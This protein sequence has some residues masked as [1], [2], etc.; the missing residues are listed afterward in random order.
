MKLA[1]IG[2]GI[3]GLVVAYLLRKRFE[4]TVY[5]ANDYVGGHTNT[6]R[7]NRPHGDYDIDTGFIVY[8]SRTYPNFIQLLTQLDVGWQETNMGFGVRDDKI[9]FEYSSESLLKFFAQKKN[10]FRTNIYQLIWDILR[11]N[12]QAADFLQKNCESVTLFDYLIKENY[13]RVFIDHFIVPMGAA[14]WSSN[15][16]QIRNF[17]AH[18]FIRFFQNHG[19]LNVTNRVVWRVINEGSV[20]YVNK[21]VSHIRGLIRLNT[22]VN[23]IIRRGDAVQV[24]SRDGVATYDHVVVATHSDQALRLLKDSSEEEQQILGAIPYQ[25]KYCHPPYRRI[26]VTQKKTSLE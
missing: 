2:T 11:F 10:L 25:K 9:D 26:Y 18:F 19:I 1:V 23:S 17:P 3:S 12:R 22:P 6:V 24:V 5:E 14:I 16:T 7:L 8:N 13:S 15:L 20:S 21:I 4:L